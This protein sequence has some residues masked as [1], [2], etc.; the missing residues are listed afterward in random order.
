MSLSRC[1]SPK[2]TNT[3]TLNPLKCFLTFPNQ[4]DIIISNQSQPFFKPDSLAIITIQRINEHIMK[5]KSSKNLTSRA[6]Y[7]TLLYSPSFLCFTA[8]P[9]YAALLIEL[10]LFARSLD[11]GN[12]NFHFFCLGGSETV[13]RVYKG[14]PRFSFSCSV[15][16]FCSGYS[17]VSCY[18]Y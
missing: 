10:K 8:L 6:D 5:L 4:S 12:F 14:C 7:T 13:F 17:T 11:V 2:P 9:F 18:V 15:S 3:F 1:D 16:L